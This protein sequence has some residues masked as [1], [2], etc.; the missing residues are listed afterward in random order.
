MKLPYF[1]CHVAC[2][3]S[4]REFGNITFINDKVCCATGAGAV[5]RYLV[6]LSSH[7]LPKYNPNARSKLSRPIIHYTVPLLDP[8]AV[9]LSRFLASFKYLES[10][11]LRRSDDPGVSRKVPFTDIDLPAMP[12]LSL[13]KFIFAGT[14]GRYLLVRVSVDSST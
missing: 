8:C 4:R 7:L 5:D 11:V 3:S 13:R 12:D 2:R 6:A 14:Q 10:A 1:E 9:S